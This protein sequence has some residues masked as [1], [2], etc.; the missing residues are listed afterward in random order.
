[1]CVILEHT[2]TH[3]DTYTHI[4][5]HTHTHHHTKAEGSTGEDHMAALKEEMAKHKLTFKKHIV[6]L[7]TDTESTMNRTGRLIVAAAKEEEDAIVEHVGCV[8]HILN[9]NVKA[10]AKDRIRSTQVGAATPAD[11][12]LKSLQTLI[13]SYNHSS[14]NHAKLKKLQEQLND[15]RDPRDRERVV[16]LIQDIVTRWWST[17]AMCERAV[18]LKPHIDTM[19]GVGQT[20]RITTNL[21]EPQWDL[22]KD[23][24]K[25]LRPF[26]K[27]QQL[28]EGESYVTISLVPQVINTLRQNLRAALAVPDNS[29][30]VTSLLTD[31]QHSFVEDW[32]SGVP[33][34]MFDEHL[35]VGRRNRHVGFRVCHMVASFL[36]PRFKKLSIFGINDRIK[37]KAEVCMCI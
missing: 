1:V 15:T 3:S 34:T 29:E 22:V 20:N 33:D 6:S 12:A 32:G 27:A 2:Q 5:T 10:G 9:L 24:V 23:I 30:Y 31:L 14:Q 37:I 8:D 16:G 25:I 19:S 13:G 18:R 11:G 7:T 35:E 21:R 26:M 28:L 17:Y 4:L 36:D